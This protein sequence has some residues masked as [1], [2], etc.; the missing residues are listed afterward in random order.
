MA[1]LGN[2]FFAY[3]HLA[4]DIYSNDD[5]DKILDETGGWIFANGS[6]WNI[7]IKKI[8]DKRSQVSLKKERYE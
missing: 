3:P 6:I 4:K 8:T 5:V 2:S 1:I 7:E